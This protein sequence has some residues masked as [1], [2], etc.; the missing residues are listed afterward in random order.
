MRNKMLNLKPHHRL[1]VPN[2]LAVIAAVL[3][4]VSGYAGYNTRQD[5]HTAEVESTPS[6]K[7]EGADDS[8]VID[9]AEHKRRGLNLGSLLFRRG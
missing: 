7:V 1:Q 6:V 9:S 5:V 4:L 3:L 8:N 2:G